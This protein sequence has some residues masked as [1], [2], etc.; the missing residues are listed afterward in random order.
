MQNKEETARDEGECRGSLNPRPLQASEG[1][2]S[3]RP[4]SLKQPQLHRPFEGSRP[5]LPCPSNPGGQSEERRGHV[6]TATTLRGRGG[7]REGR[8]RRVHVA[9]PIGQEPRRR[10]AIWRRSLVLAESGRGEATP[11]RP[12]SRLVWLRCGWERR[13]CP[14]AAMGSRVSGGHCAGEQRS[15][16]Q[17]RGWRSTEPGPRRGPRPSLSAKVSKV[18]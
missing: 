18:G 17:E 13:R 7:G 16:G 4:E 15:R 9:R 8:G 3:S 12:H 11:P 1:H 6:H 14:S 10:G 5:T 2:T